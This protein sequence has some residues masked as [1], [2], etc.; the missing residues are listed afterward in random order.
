MSNAVETT[1]LVTFAVQEHLDVCGRL[2]V[3]AQKEAEVLKSP[4]PPPSAAIQAERRALLSQL[5]STTR[6]LSDKQPLWQQL[7]GEQLGNKVRMNP[8]LQK[9]LD[10][11]MRVLV[12]D[13]ENEQ[14]LL[15]RGLLPIHALHTLRPLRTLPTVEQSRPSFVARLYQ[16][17]AKA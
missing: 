3:L 10:T 9:A 12:I 2:L 17:H 5:E 13:R 7:S 15:R 6:S 16:N 4:M 8:L 14:A 11:I 1:D